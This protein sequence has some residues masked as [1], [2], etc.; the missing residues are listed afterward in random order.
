MNLFFTLSP[1]IYFAEAQTMMSEIHIL[2]SRFHMLVSRFSSLFFIE[3]YSLGFNYKFYL[4]KM[5]FS[6]HNYRKF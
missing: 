5:F 3:H 6:L 1:F 2:P 4:L